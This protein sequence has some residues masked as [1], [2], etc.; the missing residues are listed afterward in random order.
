MKCCLCGEEYERLSRHILYYCAE[1]HR[2]NGWYR[3]PCGWQVDIGLSAGLE[4]PELPM[5]ESTCDRHYGKDQTIEQHLLRM[6]A[7]N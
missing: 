5:P 2:E 1:V 4:R 3:C 7:E 6:I